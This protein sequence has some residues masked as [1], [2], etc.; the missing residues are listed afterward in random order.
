MPIVKDAKG[1]RWK[2]EDATGVEGTLIHADGKWYSRVYSKGIK[3]G[4]LEDKI[5]TS[6]DFEVTEDELPNL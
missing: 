4:L 2:V 5:L 3:L 6:E 1:K